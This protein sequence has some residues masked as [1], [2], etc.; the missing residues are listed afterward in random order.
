MSA[1][2][3]L[4]RYQYSGVI[5]GQRWHGWAANCPTRSPWELQNIP[6]VGVKLTCLCRTPACDSGEH[7]MQFLERAVLVV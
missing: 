7:T 2:A 5:R 4:A 6:V 3:W 1:S